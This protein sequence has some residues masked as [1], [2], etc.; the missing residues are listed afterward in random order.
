[1]KDRIIEFV[2]VGKMK[3][4]ISGSIL[5]L[6]GPPGVG[7]TSIGRSI[8][9]ALGRRFYRFSLGGM[10]D[11]AEIK[12]H[13]RTYIGSMPG[14]FLQ[15][16][17][18]A[19]T[20]NPVIMLDEIDKVGASFRGDP[21]SALLEVLDPEQNSSFRDHYLDVPFDLS[22]VL[23]ISTANQVDT[24]PLPLLDRME[25]IRLSGYILEEKLEIARRHL[26]P[27]A[28]ETHGLTTKQVRITRAALRG[29][30][31]GYAREAGVRGIE[32][33][34]KKILRRSA[35]SLAK[36]PTETVVVRKDNV[37][38]FL[39]E[40]DFKRE[41]NG[42]CGTRGRNWSRLDQSWRSHTSD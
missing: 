13:R 25:I 8:A 41:G 27:R 42:C 24:I 7:K 36:D 26:I 22:N 6:V 21:A 18:T 32:K 33:Q 19:G 9:E 23:F 16:L 20:A 17:K 3:G 38:E 10:R 4:D 31:D 29:I 37:H 39:G 2:A 5:C 14:K 35:L 15:A 12:G 30:I 28:L 40:P 1:M 11:E 34:I